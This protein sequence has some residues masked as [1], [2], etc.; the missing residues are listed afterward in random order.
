MEKKTSLMDVKLKEFSKKAKTF[1]RRYRKNKAGVLGLIGLLLIVFTTV[2]APLITDILPLSNSFSINLAPNA[3]N[4]FGTDDLGRDVFSRTLYGGRM[5]LIVGILASLVSTVVGIAIGS[6]AGYMGK[7][8]DLMLMKFTEF[9]Q[10]IPQFF[11]AI[12]IAAFFGP[13][14]YGIILVIGMLGWPSTARLVRAAA[15][16]SRRGRRGSGRRRTCAPRP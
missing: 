15:R 8:V 16:G 14:F 3:I 2:L 4:W 7:S 13:S 5:S 12:M 6:V 9:F 10:I 1:W 11:L